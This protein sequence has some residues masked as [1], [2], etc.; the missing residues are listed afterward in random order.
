MPVSLGLRA[1]MDSKDKLDFQEQGGCQVKRDLR[2]RRASQGSV[3]APL[4]GI[5]SSLACRVLRDFG[6]AAPGSR[7][8]RVPQGFPDHLALLECLGYRD[9]L[10]TPVCLD[11]LGSPLNWGPYQSN[12]TSL[13][14]SAGTVS[15]GRQPTQWGSWKKERRETR[16]SPACQAW[17]AVP[18]ASRS[19]SAQ[20]L[21]RPGE[22]T[23]RGIQAVLE[24]PACPVLRDCP[25]REEK[26]VR[27]A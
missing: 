2:E 1:L 15:R 18:G 17:T 11:S 6:W 10:E 16:V 25:A 22:T 27:L 13:R 21:R 26:R 19:G 7:A 8:R 5:P 24:A 12:S 3:P 4:G 9:C 20:E 23:V 14:A